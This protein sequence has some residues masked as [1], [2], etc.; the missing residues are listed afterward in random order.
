MMQT[1][2]NMMNDTVTWNIMH[3]GIYSVSWQT[4]VM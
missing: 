2:V 3:L 4:H 1:D